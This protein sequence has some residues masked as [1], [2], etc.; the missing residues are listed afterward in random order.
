MISYGRLLA[1]SPLPL[2][3]ATPGLFVFRGHCIFCPVS[4][5]VDCN[6]V[7]FWV[8]AGRIVKGADTLISGVHTWGFEIDR[9]AWGGFI[10]GFSDLPKFGLLGACWGFREWERSCGCLRAGGGGGEGREGTYVC[11]MALYIG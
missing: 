3:L 9:G 7:C 10:I 4:G 5:M 1:L 8:W 2:R 6:A 11:S